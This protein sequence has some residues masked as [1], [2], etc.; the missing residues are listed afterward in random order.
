MT[1]CNQRVYIILSVPDSE[2]DADTLY[3]SC[4]LSP[5]YNT[6]IAKLQH[7]L[8]PDHEFYYTEYKGYTPLHMSCYWNNIDSVDSL[9]KWGAK[10]EAVD[11]RF[12]NTPLHTAST[13]GSVEAVQ[14]LLD[15]GANASKCQNC[16]VRCASICP[17][18]HFRAIA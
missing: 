16:R 12:G 14:K 3:Y 7:G 5:N 17:G 13:A 1:Q 8:N 2:E 6:V 15:Q 9:I 10:I 18:S 11:Y 4:G